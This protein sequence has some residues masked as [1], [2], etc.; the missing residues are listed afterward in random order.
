MD[1]VGY[2]YLDSWQLSIPVE[3]SVLASTQIIVYIDINYQT[4]PEVNTFNVTMDE[5]RYIS[6]NRDFSSSPQEQVLII[7]N[8]KR[9][10]IG[11][12]FL[13]V[14]EP[15]IV[16]EYVEETRNTASKWISSQF[17]WHIVQENS[18][19]NII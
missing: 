19:R 7:T 16:I 5:F 11:N 18:D 3:K 12:N 4:I 17:Q 13:S 1:K 8:N 6:F 14:T 9:G 2:K 10:Y 15:Q